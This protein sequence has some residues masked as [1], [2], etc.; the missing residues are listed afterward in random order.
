[1]IMD[2]GRMTTAAPAVL[3]VLAATAALGC[4]VPSGV[5]ACRFLVVVFAG[6]RGVTPAEPSIGDNIFL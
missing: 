4:H 1:M 3:V 2:W 5:A 6:P